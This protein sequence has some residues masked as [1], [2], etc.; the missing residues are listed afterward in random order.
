M[1]KVRV[2]CVALAGLA[3][4]AAAA[5]ADPITITSGFVGVGAFARGSFR[6]TSGSL[7]G[8]D[9]FVLDVSNSDG[10]SQSVPPCSQ[11]SPCI[12]GATTSASR[13]FSLGN[14]V[15]T[16]TIDGTTYSTLV[17]RGSRFTFTSGDVVLPPTTADAFELESPFLFQGMASIWSVDSPAQAF[18]G[19]FSLVGHGTATTRLERFGTGYAV[20]GFRYEF[21]NDT[22]SP[23]PEPASMLL[24][25]TGLVAAWQSRRLRRAQ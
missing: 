1:A 25:G 23:T 21:A 18:L 20:S 9:S 12:A 6:S 17:I 13:E 15:G 4:T 22:A 10:P 5:V 7:T 3:M 2:L 16:G 8:G 24:L 14:A 19:D 11:F